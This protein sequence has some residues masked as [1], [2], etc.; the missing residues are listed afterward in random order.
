MASPGDSGS[1]I[2][3]SEDVVQTEQAPDPQ[4]QHEDS[5]KCITAALSAVKDVASATTA[6]GSGKVEVCSDLLKH[7]RRSRRLW[8]NYDI[9]ALAAC[10]QLSSPRWE[11]DRGDITEV[12]DFAGEEIEVKKLVDPDSREAAEKAKVPG[13]SPTALDT[14]LEQ[15][16]KKPKLS[17]LDKTKKDWSEFKDE[18][19]GMEE[20]LDAYKKSSNQYLDKVSFLQRT[21]HREFERERDARLALQA[22]RRP[23]MRDD[24]L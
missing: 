17:V 24:D 12:R 18:N 9:V 4:E 6:A 15:I 19:K 7:R 11:R 3:A 10:G 22:K 16:K 21:D 1:K 14:L 2:G 5:G 23:D 8:V 20:E 13:A